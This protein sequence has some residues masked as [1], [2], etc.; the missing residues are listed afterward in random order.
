MEH[1]TLENETINK[2][3][4]DINQFEINNSTEKEYRDIRNKLIIELYNRNIR[5]TEISNMK[6][7]DIDKSFALIRIQRGDRIF[8]VAISKEISYLLKQITK[9]KD[10][11]DYIF[12][13]N[14]IETNN[15][16]RTMITKIIKNN[17][18]IDIDHTVTNQ[19]VYK[20]ENVCDKYI[21][22]KNGQAIDGLVINTIANALRI[23]DVLNADELE[24]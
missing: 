23:C 18:A 17:E 1:K 2:N 4:V 10:E 14:L 12:T 9:Y 21:I 13:K 22:F 5:Y 24:N 11:K 8:R 19:K 15:L 7:Q 16:S 6:V 3:Q 20:F